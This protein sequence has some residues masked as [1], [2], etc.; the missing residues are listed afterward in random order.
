VRLV[1]ATPHPLVVMVDA[2][3]E[4]GDVAHPSPLLL[5]SGGADDTTGA[6]QPGDL[7][8]DRAGRPGR[9]RH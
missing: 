2:L 7:P 3:V 6:A 8:G 4:A 9:R 1:Q 5:G